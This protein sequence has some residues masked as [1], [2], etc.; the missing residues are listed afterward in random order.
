MKIFVKLLISIVAFFTTPLLFALPQSHFMATS[1]TSFVYPVMTPRLSSKYGN[2]NHP[3]LHATRHH[4]GV[5]LAAP[6]GAPVRAVTKGTVVF[7]DPYKGYGNL[8]VIMH[9][10]GVTS[11]YGH[12][13]EIKVKPGQRIKAGQIIATIGSTGI[14]TGPH[15]HFELRH[16]GKILDPIKMIPDLA[17][18]GKG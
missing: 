14:S 5:D 4:N 6:L 18:K 2:R 11:H 12:L 17:I 9:S 3:I 10:N 16:N 8:V 15:L 7:A 13:N 1:D